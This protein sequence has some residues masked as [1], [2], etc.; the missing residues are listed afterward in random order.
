M[1]FIESWGW[2]EDD[3]DGDDWRKGEGSARGMDRGRNHGVYDIHDF[4]AAFEYDTLGLWHQY[5]VS[6]EYLLGHITSLIHAIED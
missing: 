5:L 6:L 1:R 2:R 4:G 3:D